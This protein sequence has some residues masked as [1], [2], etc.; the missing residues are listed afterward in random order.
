MVIVGYMVIVGREITKYTVIH[1]IYAY[2]VYI[3]TVLANP[4][5]VPTARA[6]AAHEVM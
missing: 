6:F 4:T 5:Q 1:G 2:M 3:Y